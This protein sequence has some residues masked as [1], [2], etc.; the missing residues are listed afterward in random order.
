VSPSKVHSFPITKSKD[1]K[2]DE[3]PDKKFKSNLKNY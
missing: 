3:M 1:I 2:A